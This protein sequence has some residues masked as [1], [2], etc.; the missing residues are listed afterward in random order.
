MNNNLNKNLVDNKLSKNSKFLMLCDLMY[1]T[2]GIFVSTFLVAY[3]LKITNESIIQ[4]SI[5]YIIIYSLLSLGNLL[6]G[7]FVKIKPKCRTK[8]LSVGAIL[9]AVFILLIAILKEKIAIYFPIIAILYAFSEVF[10]WVAHETI[11]I[12][13]TTNENR[14][15]YMA[16][17]TIFS[18]VINII[19][20]IV[21]GASIELY[22]FSKIAIYVF[23]ISV[24]Q[25]IA[26]LSI[27]QQNI[28][29]NE[30]TEEYSIKKFRKSLNQNQR[31]KIGKYVKSAVAYGVIESSIK[32]LVVIITIMTFKTSFNLGVLT[33][34]FSICS[35]LA[36]YLYK[37]YYNRKNSKFIL[38]T[39]STLI[40]LG[41]VGLIF[42]INKT[43]LII[44]NFL[45][46]V[47]ISILT[48]IYNTKKGDLVKECNIENW[49]IE[50]VVYVGLFIATGRVL[51]YSLMLIAG[52]FNN[53]IIFKVL[54]VMVSIFAPVYAKL[55]YDVEKY[56]DNAN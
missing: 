41:V 38:Y 48:V 27:R 43:T 3:F 25:I 49:K 29:A 32:S 52:L 40:L 18:K 24:I 31:N 54:L 13:V 15:D 11:L 30:N 55:M 21:L 22:S 47:T 17:K 36:L 51:G 46:T 26:S 16:L 37:K 10:Y 7:K 20:P 14:K 6:I 4:I 12:E 19:V 2:T 42:D 33:S 53:V 35:M 1:S 56:K 5:F 39:C 28:F 45:Y 9:R 50:Y 8:I 34:L 44:Y 23:I